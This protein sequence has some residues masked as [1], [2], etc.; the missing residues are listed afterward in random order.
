MLLWSASLQARTSTSHHTTFIKKQHSS[1]STFYLQRYNSTQATA[2]RP[3]HQPAQLKLS[4]TC[5][6]P[7][8]GRKAT[9]KAPK[10]FLAENR[11]LNVKYRQGSTLSTSP[12]QRKNWAK[13]RELWLSWG[14]SHLLQSHSPCQT[15]RLNPQ[16]STA[17]TDSQSPL[18]PY[19]QVTPLQS[20]TPAIHHPNHAQL[21]PVWEVMLLQVIPMLIPGAQDQPLPWLLTAWGMWHQSHHRWWGEN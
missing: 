10:S 17:N 12:P 11:H 2:G 8:K 21:P 13:K 7:G 4:F 6:I 18:A 20:I 9:C 1:L 3:G 16:L 19:S 15:C 5:P 14:Y